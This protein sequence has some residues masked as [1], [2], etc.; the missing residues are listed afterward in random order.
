MYYKNRG[1]CEFIGC[2]CSEHILK[3]GTEKCVNCNHGSC[4]HKK[5]NEVE[6][7]KFISFRN[8]ARI[9]IYSNINRVITENDTSFISIN[10]YDNQYYHE[11][12]KELNKSEFKQKLEK[13]KKEITENRSNI[14]YPNNFC[15][16]FEELPA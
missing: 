7:N 6:V 9:P 13:Y 5:L 1:H 3:K 8:T 4:W 15:K 12:C 14:Y 2:S 10:I 16:N 11:Y